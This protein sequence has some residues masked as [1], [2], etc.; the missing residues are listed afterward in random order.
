MRRKDKEITEKTK[1]DSILKESRICRLG[2]V[3]GDRAYVVPVNFGYRNNSLYIHSASG[4]KKIEL[5]KNSK[6]VTFQADID[7]E[8][9]S[10]EKAC[11]FTMKYR[12][13]MGYGRVVFL[14]TEENKREALNIIMEK[15][16]GRRD[17]D[18]PDR[19]LAKTVL[20]RIDIDEVSGKISGWKEE[21][22]P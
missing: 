8:I 21:E 20:I 3:D 15:Y 17:W 7:T 6:G 22:N 12:S 10:A 18:F 14:Q 16:S 11:R 4:G 19:E 13:V 2:M 5:L 1:I 9:V